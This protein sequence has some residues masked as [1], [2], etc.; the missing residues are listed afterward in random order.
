MSSNSYRLAVFSSEYE[1]RFRLVHVEVLHVGLM[2][3]PDQ[4]LVVGQHGAFHFFL[5]HIALCL[6]LQLL[7]LW[8]PTKPDSWY[9]ETFIIRNS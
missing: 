1:P 2:D 6:Q 3:L 4:N 7:R 5:H 8:H 9:T